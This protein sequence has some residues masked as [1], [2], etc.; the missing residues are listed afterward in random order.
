MKAVTWLLVAIMASPGLVGA[1]E[2]FGRLF[3]TP[4][5]RASLDTQRKLAGDL[6]NRPAVRK[7]PV[8]AA[9]TA[10]QPKMV[11]LNGIVRRSD[12]ETT[13]WVNS[14]PVHESFDDVDVTPGSITREA[15]A[16][17]LPGSGRRVKLKVGQTVDA[18]TGR[19]DENYRRAP[20][21][22]AEEP[23][24]ETSTPAAAPAPSR[25]AARRR[26]SSLRDYE[27]APPAAPNRET[28]SAPAQSDGSLQEY[29]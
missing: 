6:A 2:K 13:I 9:K 4:A 5:E 26:K 27:P 22:A 20:P 21:E 25:A 14:Q 15:V 12:G 24:G 16:V 8:I 17:Q 7:D 29:Q 1:Q 10:P 3:F 11:T 19:V 28:A 18:A 23:V